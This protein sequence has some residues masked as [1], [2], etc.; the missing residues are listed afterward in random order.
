MRI[1]EIDGNLDIKTLEHGS[2]RLDELRPSQVR[3]LTKGEHTPIGIARKLESMGYDFADSGKFSD[4]YINPNS[5]IV[6]KVSKRDDPCWEG[7]AEMVRKHG[8][9]NPFLPRVASV[10]RVDS[11]HGSYFIAFMEKLLPLRGP[12]RFDLATWIDDAYAAL[13]TNEITPDDLMDGLDER[14]MPIRTPERIQNMINDHLVEAIILIYKH[15][16]EGCWNDMHEDNF[17]MRDNGQVVITDPT[18]LR[19]APSSWGWA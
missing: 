1:N 14:K 7:F 10:Q 3:D 18:F 4:I 2:D 16:P 6:V 19:D 17:M 13:E 12:D 9:G 8:R 5:K 15:A 11:R